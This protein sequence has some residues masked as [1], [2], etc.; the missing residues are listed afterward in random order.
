MRIVLLSCPVRSCQDEQA[1]SVVSGYA[2]GRTLSTGGVRL[3]T[4]AGRS[5]PCLL[6][7]RPHWT[8]TSGRPDGRR[9]PP[10]PSAGEPLPGVRTRTDRRG[11]WPGGCPVTTPGR[12]LAARLPVGMS[13]RRGEVLEVPPSG[14]GLGAGADGRMGKAGGVSGHRQA[15]RVRRPAACRPHASSPT[16]LI[17]RGVKRSARSQGRARYRE[18]NRTYPVSEP[19]LK[20]LS[21]Y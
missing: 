12:K 9:V 10:C 17:A 15:A 19:E 4:L 2:H 6:A 7:G 14:P 1:A 5:R 18:A 21:I 3:W 13:P 20:F 11:R 16:S 8:G